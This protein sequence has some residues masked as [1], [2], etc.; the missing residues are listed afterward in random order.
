LTLAA[1][2]RFNTV[3]YQAQ[4]RYFLA[5]SAVM[6]AALAGG[7]TG[8]APRDREHIPAILLVLVMAAMSV[9]ALVAHVTGGYSFAPP[10][11][12]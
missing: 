12:G 11:A 2:M 4:A 9:W 7:I 6:A 1:F 3:F 8:L 10:G 5:A